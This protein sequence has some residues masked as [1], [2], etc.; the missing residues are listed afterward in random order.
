MVVRKNSTPT[1]SNMPLSVLDVI[2]DPVLLIDSGQ[3][4]NKTGGDH[5]DEW[6]EKSGNKSYMILGISVEC[7]ITY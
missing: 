4:E 2:R 1:D 7:Y 3:T 6:D 5:S